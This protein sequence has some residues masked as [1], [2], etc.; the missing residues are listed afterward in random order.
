ML[1]L[2]IIL[3]VLCSLVTLVWFTRHLMINVEKRSGFLLCDAYQGPPAGAPSLSV[4]VA[5]KDEEANIET[6]VRTMLDQDYPDYEVIVCNDRSSDRTAEIVQEIARQDGRVRL[7][8]I[9]KLPDGWFGKNNAMQHGIAQARGKWICMID[10]DCRQTSPRTLS[11]A[12]QY[13]ADTKAD[14]L[15]V[16]PQLEMKGFWE[17]AVQPVC[18]G[19]MM[20]WF[21]PD[22]VN[23][24]ATPNAYANGAFMLMSKDAYHAIGTHEAVRQ[25][26]NEDMHIAR[27]VKEKKLNLRVVRGPKLYCVRMYTSLQQILRGWSRIFF[28]TFGTLPRLIT[29]LTVLVMMGLLPYISAAMGLSLALAGAQNALAWAL[30]GVAGMTASAM[31]VSAIYRFYRLIGAQ[32]NLCWSYSIGAAVAMVALFMSL[33]RLRKGAKVTWRGTAYPSN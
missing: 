20:I 16:L 17:N 22:K 8:N 24:P 29:S 6:C 7:V 31:Q 14:L 19:V 2:A 33:S 11:V 4:V 21:H 28:G 10:A 12:M 23:N 30:C 18:S 9:E 26:L 1:I 25:C 3:T 15:S 32:A 27:L 5:A 13:A